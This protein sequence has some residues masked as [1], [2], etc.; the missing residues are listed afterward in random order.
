MNVPNIRCLGLNLSHKQGYVESHGIIIPIPTLSSK[1]INVAPSIDDLCITARI[2]K[3]IENPYVV[4]SL[5]SEEANIGEDFTQNMS[6]PAR[7][8]KHICFSSS[9]P[10]DD[11]ENCGSIPPIG[12]TTKPMVQHEPSLTPSPFPQADTVHQAER[13]LLHHHPLIFLF[14]IR[15]TRSINK[16]LAKV[17]RNVATM[18]RYMA[19]DGE[20]VDD[21][22]VDDTPPNSPSDKP[23]PPPSPPSHPPPK[24]PSTLLRNL[25]LPKRGRIIK[26]SSANANGYYIST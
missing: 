15:L 12:D 22:V 19:L 11:T 9:S 6:S 26:G 21:I 20:D 3:W 17:E 14:F 18:N 10:D 7:K 1:I 16:S 2:R 8:N 13:I 23:P 24:T 25:M 4:E 5:D